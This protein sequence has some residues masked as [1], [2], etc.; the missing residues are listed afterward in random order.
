MLVC[1]FTFIAAAIGVGIDAVPTE[2]TISKFATVL[3]LVCE[4]GRMM[5]SNDDLL[6]H[7]CK[8]YIYIYI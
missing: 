4:E 3:P 6:N 2:A 8:Y 7:I 1:R 5:M